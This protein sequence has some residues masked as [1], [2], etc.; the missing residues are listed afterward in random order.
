MPI[1]LLIQEIVVNFQKQEQLY[2]T[3]ADLST[4]QLGLLEHDDWL[5]KP[6][7]L[8]DLLKKRQDIIKNIDRLNNDNKALQNEVNRQLAISD[9]VLSRL[10]PKI[11]EEQYE[12]LRQVIVRLGD[13]L[14]DINKMDEQSNILIKRQAGYSKPAIHA[15]RQQVQNAYQEAMQQARK[16]SH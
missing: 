13:L 4:K 7:T 2:L 16:P 11:N 8:N 3:I 6:E 1:S 15:N 14:A 12:S 9:F 10:E 5:T